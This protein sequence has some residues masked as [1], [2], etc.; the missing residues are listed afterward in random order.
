MLRLF[1]GL[2]CW[3]AITTVASSSYSGR[4][5][6]YRRSFNSTASPAHKWGFSS[7]PTYVVLAT[8]KPSRRSQL[9]PMVINTWNFTDANAFAWRILQQ[10]EGGLGQTRNAVVEGCT[11]CEQLQCD[12]T[13]G[14]GGSPDELGDTTL[15]ALVMDG[16]TMNVGAVAGLQGIKD[17]IQVARHVLER[18]SHTLLVGNSASEFAKSMGFRPE[19]L[20]TPESKLMWQNWKAGNCQPNFWHDVHPNPRISCGPY[21]PQAT[22]ITHWKED[23]ARTEFQMGHKNHD[24][25]GMIA[26]DVQQQIHVGTS[27]NGARFKIPGRVGDSPIPGAGGYAD[28]EAGA[29]VATGDGDIM[30]RFLPTLLAV[31]AM[32]SGKT[33][34]QAAEAS[35]QRILKRH[36]DFSGAVIAVNRLGEYA[37]A[38]YGMS[39]FPFMVSSPLQGT[40][41]ETVKCLAPLVDVTVVPLA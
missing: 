21:E 18:T 4:G 31:E 9:L 28:N 10:S 36:K 29:A 19:T 24:T 30:M 12:G 27:T 6:T 1:I 35:V 32:R 40:Q 5:F 11:K 41:M 33:P 16:A 22:P 8:T 7:N 23:R 26:I 15:D 2:L 20:V 13:V 34:G 14:Y 25:I 3:A 17:A 38:C 39:E 37:A